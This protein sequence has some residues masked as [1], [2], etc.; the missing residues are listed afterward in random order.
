MTENH[1]CRKCGCEFNP[2]PTRIKKRD[3]ICNPCFNE[4]ANARNKRIRDAGFSFKR[5]PS[6]K[7]ISQTDVKEYFDY[8]D[9]WLV[10]KKKLSNK[11]I[12]GNKVGYPDAHGYIQFGFFGRM[13]KAH[14]MIFLWHHGCSPESIDHI[15][16]D[17][18]DNRIENLRAATTQQNSRNARIRKDSG[19]GRKGV[20]YFKQ[21]GR[22]QAYVGHNGQNIHVGYFDT[23][24][25]AHKARSKLAEKLHGEFVCH[26]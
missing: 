23:A 10:W 25:D 17:T 4:Y 19:T 11:T 26:G 6:S 7:E 8:K 21:T 5:K 18:K 13:V 9:G 2:T 22:Y 12:P 3:F 16:H 14:R 1:I 20:H 15:N 24:E